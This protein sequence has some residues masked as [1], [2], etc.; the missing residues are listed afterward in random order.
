MGVRHWRFI[1]ASSTTPIVRMS[2][3]DEII[4][5]SIGSNY[6]IVMPDLSLVTFKVVILLV[7]KMA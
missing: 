2:Q 1:I 6:R 7:Q 3:E 4:E 5:K